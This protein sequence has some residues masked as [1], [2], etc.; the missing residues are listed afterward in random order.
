MEVLD[1]KCPSCSSVLKYNPELSK[2][3]C[4][5]CS[6]E[7]LLEDLIENEKEFE[8]LTTHET[9]D[10]DEYTC[11]NCGAKIITDEN[12]TATFC[13]Y[14][15]NTAIIKNRITG[16]LKPDGVIPFKISDKDEIRKQFKAFVKSKPFVP[17]WFCKE[18]RLEKIIPIYV[19]FWILDYNVNGTV[20]AVVAETSY[21][22]FSHTVYIGDTKIDTVSSK[23]YKYD[24]VCSGTVKFKNIPADASV[25]YNDKLMDSVEPFDFSELKEF[26]PAYLSGFYAEKYDI[27]KKT[28]KRRAEERIKPTFKECLYDKAYQRYEP[29]S[30]SNLKM[31]ME[32]KSGKYVLLPVWLLNIDYADEKILFAINGQTGYLVG[33][34]PVSVDKIILY[35]ITV[36]GVIFGSILLLFNF[37]LIDNPFYLLIVGTISLIITFLKYKLHHKVT[38]KAKDAYEY[39]ESKDID[40][41][42]TKFRIL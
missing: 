32:L 15:G 36:F 25:K 19:P 23:K 3:K 11:S 39:I 6:N 27:G 18:A 16:I 38:K 35:F 26:T 9:M 40:I 4:E 28:V 7:Y 12:T 34:V 10:V 2:W 20:D 17:F 31:S 13:V 30:F 41:R 5:H 29:I 22:N 21:D 8:D 1:Y 33:D 42:T 24:A 14:C 37:Q